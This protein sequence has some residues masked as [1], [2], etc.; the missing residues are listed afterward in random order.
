VTPVLI[1]LRHKVL[2]P[3]PLVEGLR[4]NGIVDEICVCHL[5]VSL[6]SRFISIEVGGQVILPKERYGEV[7]PR[8]LGAAVPFRSRRKYV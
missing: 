4:L 6:I 1:E 7:A 5:L 3:L 8:I 2:P